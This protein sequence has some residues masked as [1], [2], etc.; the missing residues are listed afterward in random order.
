M[1]AAIF[2][3]LGIWQDARKLCKDIFIITKNNLFC[4]DY[5]LCD[6]IRTSSG[7]VM[8]NIAEGFE[9]NGNKEFIQFL[10]IAKGS[11]GE[12][13]SQS[14]RAFDY[15]Y[16]DIETL[17]DLIYKTKTLSKQISGF[18]SYLKRSDL[19]GSKYQ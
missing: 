14:Y 13:R 11:C 7:S 5:K 1:K 18:M 10:S 9:R 8:D 15:E 12:C 16:I 17:N 6:Q 4:K 2:E 19:K 3:D